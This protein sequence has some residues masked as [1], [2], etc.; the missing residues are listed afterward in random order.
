LLIRLKLL[1]LVEVSVTLGL[2]GKVFCWS[3]VAAEFS[4]SKQT[5]INVKYVI[6]FH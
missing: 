6:E 1:G 5:V 4:A 2:C 3:T